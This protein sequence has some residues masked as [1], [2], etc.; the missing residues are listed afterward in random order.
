MHY[1]YTHF[2]NIRNISDLHIGRE[3]LELSTLLYSQIRRM[4]CLVIY[5]S[6]AKH[7]VKDIQQFEIS[8]IY[9]PIFDNWKVCDQFELFRQQKVRSQFFL[10]DLLIYFFLCKLV[11]KICSI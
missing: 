11:L 1:L 9:F 10:S 2:A 4:M 6:H 3:Y 5:L 7:F 8:K